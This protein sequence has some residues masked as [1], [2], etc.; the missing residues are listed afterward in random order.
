MLAK[1]R[2][3]DP[4]TTVRTLLRILVNFATAGRADKQFVAIAII[5]DPFLIVFVNMSHGISSCVEKRMS[6]A[7]LNLPMAML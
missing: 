3:N 2:G 1:I 6:A 5:L 4:F 7:L